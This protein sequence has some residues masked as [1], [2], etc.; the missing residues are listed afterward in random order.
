MTGNYDIPFVLAAVLGVIGGVMTIVFDLIT[1]TR[2]KSQ[3]NVIATVIMET[4][5][6]RAASEIPCD[7]QLVK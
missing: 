3:S 6:D 4:V 7:T 2:N 5:E 1:N